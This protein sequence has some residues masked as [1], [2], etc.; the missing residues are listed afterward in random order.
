MKRYYYSYS[1][2]LGDM[3]ILVEKMDRYRPDAIVAI[4]RGGTTI[5]H[6]LS[7]YFSLRSLFTINSVLYDGIKKLDEIQIFNVP[8]LTGYENVLIV[9]DIADS[10]ATLT[11]IVDLLKSKYPNSSFKT[12]TVFQKQSGKFR[13]DWYAKEAIEWI[14]FF[15]SVDL[16][17]DN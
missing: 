1:E 7:E 14:D 5:G 8:D 6:M 10:G 13:A 3:H 12:A 9:D 11:A 17:A 16:I 2:F 4:S 15:W